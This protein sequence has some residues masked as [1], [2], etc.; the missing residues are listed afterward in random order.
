MLFESGKNIS[1]TKGD[2]IESNG[3]LLELT[4]PLARLSRSEARGKLFSCLGEFFWYMSGDNDLSMISYY[5]N[6]YKELSDDGKS[7]TGGYG[8]RL[9]S[10]RGKT[11]QVQN[12]IK[13]LSEKST[14]R[15]AVIQIFNAEDL[16][17]YYRDIPCTCTLQFLARDNRLNLIAHMRSND[18]YLGLP[19]DVFCFT[20]LQE[21]IA[22]S[23]GLDLGTYKHLVGSM[24]LYKMHFEQAKRFLREG[25]QDKIAMPKMP[26]GSQLE[27]I[28]I[29][30]S[31]ERKIRL[32]TDDENLDLGLEKYW[33]D[34]IKLLRFYRATRNE[35]QDLDAAK[36]ILANNDLGIYKPYLIT[37]IDEL[38]KVLV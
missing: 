13:L 20:M 4:N 22:R 5:L 10:M 28:K 21:V 11:N 25:W 3:I 15:R 33:E 16:A 14:S 8:P 9:F 24:H 34:I 6:R 30:L 31:Y 12:V 29:G 1:A 2:N 27:A 32:G 35:N 36:K 37:R 18:A 19:H 26:E 23:L 17:K 38:L 7:I